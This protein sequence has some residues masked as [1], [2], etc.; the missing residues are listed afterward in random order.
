MESNLC[1]STR[2]LH[3]NFY[4]SVVLFSVATLQVLLGVVP[5]H[6]GSTCA[7]VEYVVDSPK[8]QEEAMNTRRQ[9]P[10]PLALFDK[11]DVRTDR[12]TG[13]TA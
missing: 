7:C 8:R 5:S 4:S 11:C 1:I 12:N 9:S 6:I 2:S 13:P 3:I 10:H